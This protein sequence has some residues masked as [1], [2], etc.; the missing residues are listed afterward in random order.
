MASVSRWATPPDGSSSSST[1][2]SWASTQASSTMRRVPVDSSPTSFSRKAPSP[3]ISTSCSAFCATSASES[4]DA[5][6][7][8]PAATMSR[9]CRWRS[10]A[11]AIVS[12]TVSDGKSRASWKVRPS[13]AAARM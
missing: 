4:S 10:W 2:G 11:T 1:P 7:R 3:I 12:A 13:P 6:R 9:D 8:S 5:G